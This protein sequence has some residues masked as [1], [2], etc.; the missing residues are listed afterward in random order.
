[1][2]RVYMKVFLLDYILLGSDSKVDNPSYPGNNRD[3]EETTKKTD[4]CKLNQNCSRNQI[5]LKGQCID[6]CA[7][8]ICDRNAYCVTDEYRVAMCICNPGFTGQN[9][10][11]CG[12]IRLQVDPF[13]L[14]AKSKDAAEKNKETDACQAG[15]CGPNSE[16]KLLYQDHVDCKCKDGY[17][18]FPPKCLPQCEH[19]KDCPADTICRTTVG[20]YPAC[21]ELCGATMCGINAECVRRNGTVDLFIKVES[22]SCLCKKDYTGDPHVQCNLITAGKDCTVDND[23]SSRQRCETAATYRKCVDPCAQ[24]RCPFNTEC[25]TVNHLATCVCPAGF[26]GSPLLGCTKDVSLEVEQFSSKLSLNRSSSETNVKDCA[27]MI[28]GLFSE[29]RIVN[30]EAKCFCQSNYIGTPPNCKQEC[31]TNIDCPAEKA[32]I[33]Q[34]CRNACRNKCG[35]NARCRVDSGVL[36]TPICTCRNGFEGN[37][38]I[39]CTPIRDV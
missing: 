30:G 13:K 18:G 17:T 6:P 11:D 39:D 34:R 26:T 15:A 28:C 37:P 19:N 14:E 32:C 9:G 1:M 20:A 25:Q 4:E 8:K 36:R 33:Q 5:C 3:Q 31:I 38:N 10:K 7:I 22:K 2:K 27:S 12:P 23:C 24:H 16:C 29:C 35:R 21:T